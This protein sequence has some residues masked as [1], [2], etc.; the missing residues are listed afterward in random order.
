ML[1]VNVGCM[2]G[3]SPPWRS[4]RRPTSAAATSSSEAQSK[5]EQMVGELNTKVCEGWVVGEISHPGLWI[6]GTT[7]HSLLF[8]SVLTYVLLI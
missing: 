8:F 3:S 2:D 4:E 7:Y 5:P 1:M 6:P